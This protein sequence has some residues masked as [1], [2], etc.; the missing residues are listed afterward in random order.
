MDV[1]TAARRSSVEEEEED[2]EELAL[3]AASVICLF[4]VDSRERKRCT[5]T[6][7]WCLIF[8]ISS[9][10]LGSGLAKSGS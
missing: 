2:E 3:N 9:R 10:R 8:S 1:P 4:W 6:E 7:G 5:L